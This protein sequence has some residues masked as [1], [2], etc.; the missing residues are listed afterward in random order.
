MFFGGV[1]GLFPYWG[2]AKTSSRPW[3]AHEPDTAAGI[4][5]RPLEVDGLF[6]NFGFLGI[7]GIESDL[8]C[9]IHVII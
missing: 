4:N 3:V 1:V 6:R 9:K 8:A 2:P 5:R 7:P